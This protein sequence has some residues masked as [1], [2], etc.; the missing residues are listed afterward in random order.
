M[1]SSPKILQPAPLGKTPGDQPATV[2]LFTNAWA[3]GG[4]EQH[5]LDLGRSLVR[6]GYHVTAILYATPAIDP[7]R[8]GL[9]ASGVQV[10]NLEGGAG[11]L[12]RARRFWQIFVVLGQTPGCIV[13]LIEGWPAGDGLAIL[14]ARLSGAAAIVKTEQQPPVSP[15]G[16]KQKLLTRA[17]DKFIKRV[18]CVSQENLRQ[19]ASIV[20]RD[21]KKM[22]VI[23]NAIDTSRFIE[24][25]DISDGTPRQHHQV[26][27]TVA[28]LAEERKGIAYFIEMA[29][30]IARDRENVRFAIV[31]DGPLRPRLEEQARRL[32]LSDRVFF[33]GERPD[34]PRLL[35]SMTM[36]VQP[37]LA[38]GASYALLEAMAA[39]VPVVATPV[40][41]A[42]EIIRNGETGF[43][44]PVRDAQALAA[45]VARL[46]DDEPLRHKIATAARELVVTRYSV[47]AMVARYI[48]LYRQVSLS[49]PVSSK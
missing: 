35:R 1:S 20:G 23:P 18:V 29:D 47:E 28:R 42:P 25:H 11:V 12:G 5:V 39:G 36:F 31:G 3:M 10:H 2:V 34:V 13:H 40:G 8:H 15:V 44:V 43:I 19:H 37:S 4:M 24:H 38:E 49:R 30:I 41:S 22:I 48:D 16:I 21:I 9:R 32:G 6:H 45:A 33:Y 17:K 27:G 46:L 7:L 14:A 26:I